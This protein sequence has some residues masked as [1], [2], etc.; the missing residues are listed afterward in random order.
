[1]LRSREPGQ[2]VVEF[3]IVAILFTLLMFA[4]VDFGLLLNSWVAL[5]SGT[6]QVA[7]AATVGYVATDLSSMVSSLTLPGVSRQAYTPFAKYCCGE[8]GSRDEVVLSV[9]YYDGS[10]GLA[11]I[12]GASG[13]NPLD[14][15]TRVDNHYWGGGF[16]CSTWPIP[17]AGIHPLRGDMIVVSVSA[18]GMEVVTPLVRPFFGCASDQLHCNVQLASSAIMRYEGQ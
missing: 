14:T 1:M 4:I 8:S 3:G 2:S 13:C 17:C 12:P 16:S 9:A 18:P 15:S 11:C 7:R 5:S 6:R 10:S